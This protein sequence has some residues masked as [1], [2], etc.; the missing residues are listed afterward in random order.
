MKTAGSWN[1]P[2]VDA[3][4]SAVWHRVED[5]IGSGRLA[6]GVAWRWRWRGISGAEGLATLLLSECRGKQLKA[7]DSTTNGSLNAGASLRRWVTLLNP[8]V[9]G[10]K[11]NA[12]GV[13]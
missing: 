12:A 4:S 8:L 2:R 1:R 9:D 3:D 10:L 7:R 5:G 6:A 13:G 11:A